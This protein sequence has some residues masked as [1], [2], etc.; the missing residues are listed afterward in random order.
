MLDRIDLH[1]EVTPV[2]LSELSSKKEYEKSDKRK[3]YK[4]EYSRTK[5]NC[6]Y[7]DKEMNRSS[8]QKHVKHSCTKFS[9]E[10]NDV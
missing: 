10:K 4:K 2:A 3:E 5:V 8:L 1:V 9:C 7:C 6:Q